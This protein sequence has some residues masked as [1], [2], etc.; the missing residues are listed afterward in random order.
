VAAA[1]NAGPHRVLGWLVSFGHLETDEFI[2]HIPF[3]ETRNY[4]KKVLLNNSAYRM[5]YAKD[6]KPFKWLAEPLGVAIPSK[7]PTHESWDAI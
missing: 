7:I 2:E 4:V 6:Q 3:V 1:Y 5:I